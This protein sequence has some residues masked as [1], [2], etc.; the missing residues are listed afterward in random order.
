MLDETDRAALVLS[1][2]PAFAARMDQ[3]IAGGHGRADWTIVGKDF[4]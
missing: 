1:F 3:V 2:L 4:L